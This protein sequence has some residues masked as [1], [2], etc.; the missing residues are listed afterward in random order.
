MTPGDGRVGPGGDGSSARGRATSGACVYC[1]TDAEAWEA[2][3]CPACGSPYHHDC[4]AENGGCAVPGC[5]T[6]AS[7]QAPTPTGQTPVVPG[8]VPPPPPSMPSGPS[9]MP[10]APSASGDPSHAASPGAAA[11]GASSWSSASS[12]PGAP[13][14]EAVDLGEALRSVGGAMDGVADRVGIP[15]QYR[16]LAWAALALVAVVLLWNLFSGPSAAAQLEEL[17]VDTCDRMDGQMFIALPAILEPAFDEAEALGF[18][19]YELGDALRDE[20]PSIM[21]QIEDW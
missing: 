9:V 2:R 18:T 12:T 15:S 3:F 20:C 4:W 16:P 13:G 10:S 7:P 21:R 1:Q 14:P 6:S 8:S 11:R 17:A 5:S 19:T